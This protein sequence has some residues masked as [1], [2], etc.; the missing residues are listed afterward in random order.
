MKKILIFLLTGFERQGWLNP[1]LV[2]RL[3]AMQTQGYMVQIQFAFS[4]FSVT[5]ARNHACN[6]ALETGA[7][8]LVQID[9]DICPPANFLDVIPQAEHAAVSI[10]GLPCM[11]VHPDGIRPVYKKLPQEST[12]GFAAVDWIGAG[13]LFVKTDALKSIPR[14]WFLADERG[15]KED[16]Y[17]C[18]KAQAAGIQVYTNEAFPADHLRTHVLRLVNMTVE[19]EDSKSPCDVGCWYAKQT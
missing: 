19:N 14:P 13:C 4:P 2:A 8:W 18:K 15:M 11:T 17:F 9:N 3:L 12:N 6:A 7:N 10:V 16:S 1:G 5:Y